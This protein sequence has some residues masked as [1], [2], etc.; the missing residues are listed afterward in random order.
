M[1]KGYNSDLSVRGKSYHVQSEDWGAERAFLVSRVFSNGAVLQTIK[2]PYQNV[3]RSTVQA[4]S[5]RD[6]EALAQALRRQHLETIE[7][8]Q[9]GAIL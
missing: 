6:P 3:L 4:A 2:V 9:S 5:I 8:V 1:L 7:K